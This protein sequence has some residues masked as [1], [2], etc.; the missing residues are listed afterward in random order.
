MVLGTLANGA[1]FG[2]GSLLANEAWKNGYAHRDALYKILEQVYQEYRLSGNP[3]EFLSRMYHLMRSDKLES[4]DSGVLG[5][6]TYSSLR[7]LTGSTPVGVVAGALMGMT[8]EALWKGLYAEMKGVSGAE[9][10]YTS[11]HGQS[12]PQKSWLQELTNSYDY[13]YRGPVYPPS[14]IEKADATSAWVSLNEA[15]V[16]PGHFSDQNGLPANQSVKHNRIREWLEV[17]GKRD[18]WDLPPVQNGQLFRHPVFEQVLRNVDAQIEQEKL[19]NMPEALMAD[20]K[21]AWNSLDSSQSDQ[22]VL[23][24]LRENGLAT[25]LAYLTANSLDQRENATE[26]VAGTEVSSL[27][28]QGGASDLPDQKY[29]GASTAETDEQKQQKSDERLHAGDGADDQAYAHNNAFFGDAEDPNRREKNE[30]GFFEQAQDTLNDYMNL[31]RVAYDMDR[32]TVPNKPDY[33]QPWVLHHADGKFPL[34]QFTATNFGLI[35]QSIANY[36]AWQNR[37]NV[38]GDSIQH[39]LY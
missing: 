34:D 18:R 4:I 10:V 6:L 30:K 35:S 1:I 14:P 26:R 24:Y 7:G 13:R 21:R 12:D 22:E 27:N 23:D 20:L 2:A 32:L 11:T 16:E 19:G 33:M 3:R 9:S 38:I 37:A 8:T 39:M 5:Y 31:S 17:L 28:R 15:G 29:A 36:R 25:L